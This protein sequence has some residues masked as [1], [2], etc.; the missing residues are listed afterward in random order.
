MMSIA[1]E[2]N[3]SRILILQTREMYYASI[4]FEDIVYLYVESRHDIFPTSRG[5][6]NL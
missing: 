3:V 5:H 6:F 2:V 1:G 4:L